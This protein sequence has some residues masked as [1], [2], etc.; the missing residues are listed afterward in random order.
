MKTSWPRLSRSDAAPTVAMIASVVVTSAL[1]V[2]PFGGGSDTPDAAL[3]RS[4]Q[5][6]I[7]PEPTTTAVSATPTT[8]PVPVTPSTSLPSPS[9]T[10]RVASLGPAP[11][12][13]I[14]TPNAPP[15]T[16]MRPATA[17]QEIQTV[18]PIR[19][20][21]L[22]VGDRLEA[23]DAAGA[24]QLDATDLEATVRVIGPAADPPIEQVD[25]L[26]WDDGS[27]DPERTLESVTGPTVQVG[28]EI[29]IR[30][31]VELGDGVPL[32]DEAV[33][34]SEQVGQI[35]VPVGLPTWVISARAVREN[36]ELIPQSVTYQAVAVIS[37][38]GLV[39]VEATNL[40]PTPEALWTIEAK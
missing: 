19:D 26:A 28:L 25:F 18:P 16:P 5:M 30:V 9:T 21:L 13:S 17:V 38:N 12:P 32:G 6:V 24:V 34:R 27:I 35:R 31:V 39:A 10:E 22:V 4:T 36:G 40:R 20:L 8:K 11:Q 15:E 3:P 29:R 14:T 1:L 23:T 33:L 2:A 37:D 7:Q